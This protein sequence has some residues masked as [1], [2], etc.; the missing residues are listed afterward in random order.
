MAMRGRKD[1]IAEKIHRYEAANLACA[2]M[3]LENEGRFGGE[4]S[5]MVKWAKA[6][7]NN[8]KQTPADK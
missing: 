4:G 6:V 3:I 5:L 2:R 1:N 8:L 7:I